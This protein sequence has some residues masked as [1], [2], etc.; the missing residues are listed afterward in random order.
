MDFDDIFENNGKHRK[1]GH[2]ENGHYEN[3]HRENGHRE[4]EFHHEHDSSGYQSFNQTIMLRS[5]LDKLKNNK[6]L[7]ILVG[8]AAV[9]LF[10]LFIVL[11]IVLMPLISKM[12]NYIGENGIQGA[13]DYVGGF[14]DRLWGGAKSK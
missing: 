5:F 11:L 10:F 13:V 12:V 1:N 8:L 14:M 9:V 6:Q 7:R 3:G 4:K 2:H